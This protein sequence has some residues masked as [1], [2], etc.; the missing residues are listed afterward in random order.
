MQK[1]LLFF[2]ILLTSQFLIE[3]QIKNFICTL[4]KKSL[5]IDL[6]NNNLISNT[7]SF[8][9]SFWAKYQLTSNFPLF[10]LD[11]LK[12]KKVFGID[13]QQNLTINGLKTLLGPLKPSLDISDS[14]FFSDWNYFVIFLKRDKNSDSYNLNI[15][16]NNLKLEKNFSFKTDN[17]FFYLILGSDKFNGD[18]KVLAEF[19]HV[20]LYNNKE[21]FT[22]D[23]ITDLSAEKAKIIFLSKFNQHPSYNKIYFNLL[24]NGIGGIRNGIANNSFNFFTSLSNSNNKARIKQHLIHDLSL[25]ILPDFLEER[26]VNQSYVYAIQ[27][28]FFYKDFKKS[29]FRNHYDHVLYQR[30]SAAGV[31]ILIRSEIHVLMGQIDNEIIL[32]NFIDEKIVNSTPIQL[33][34]SRSNILKKIDIKYLIIKVIQNPLSNFPIITFENGYT[35]NPQ[36]FKFSV[37]LSPSDKH[38]IGDNQKRDSTRKEYFSFVNIKEVLFTK[39]G[40]IKKNEEQG[41][42]RFFSGFNQNVDEVLIC[43]NINDIN[44]GNF[45]NLNLL[46]CE[47]NIEECSIGNCDVCNGSICEICEVGYELNGGNCEKCGDDQG[48]DIIFRECFDGELISE[49]FSTQFG[50]LIS[51]N[52]TLIVNP[53]D[54]LLITLKFKINPETFSNNAFYFFINNVDSHNRMMDICFEECEDKV[55]EIHFALSELKEI[56]IL[57]KLI[58]GNSGTYGIIPKSIIY[59]LKPRDTIPLEKKPINFDCKILDP[60]FIFILEKDSQNFGKCIEKCPVGQYSDKKT[61]TCLKCAKNC[62]SCISKD[63]C[64]K[65]KENEILINKN[66]QKCQLPCTRCIKTPNT[67]LACSSEEFFDPK[68]NNC[69]KKCVEKKKNCETCNFKNGKC[70]KCEFGY[71]LR[72]NECFLNLCNVKN[73]QKCKGV[74]I[75]ERCKSGFIEENGF[76][77]VCKRNCQTC[78]TG[79]TLNFRKICVV[80]VKKEKE[81]DVVP[82]YVPDRSEEK[83]IVEFVG[84]RTF[85]F[86]FIISLLEFL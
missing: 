21:T 59:S 29:N 73:C 8:S 39:G 54:I 45:G 27:F 26:D 65:C 6:K 17:E 76:C 18:C 66:C 62:Q 37:K 38:L 79:Y 1:Q 83:E 71:V 57:Q 86:A 69:L 34:M 68:Q 40:F 12:S 85:I 44:R 53:G 48:F 4:S 84:I 35:K 75:C 20:F 32:R 13:S 77:E 49:F 64:V 67:C 33:K 22:P 70:A 7:D 24:D 47:E 11:S 58:F 10:T 23:E 25:F 30:L 60:N 9:I 74:N 72:E 80:T 81:K 3:E 16:V 36:K 41:T 56:F 50:N 42:V 46:S 61:N 43:K 52:S 2:L 31:E 15:L 19:Q 82:P 78:P 63:E 55:H 14:D 5:S 28:D 51:T